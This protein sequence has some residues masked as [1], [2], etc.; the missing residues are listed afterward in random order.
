MVRFLG[1]RLLVAIPVLFGVV[2]LVFLVLRLIPGDPAQIV[3]MGTNASPERVEQVRHQMGLD[4]PWFT[5]FILY[6]GGLLQHARGFCAITNPL[7]N[8]YKRLVPGYEAPVY[9]A[10]SQ[11]NR[12]ALVRVPVYHPGKEQATRCEV[13]RA[14][15]GAEDHRCATAGTV[16]VRRG[17]WRRRLARRRGGGRLGE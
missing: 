13:C 15:E 16:P 10:W 1:R 11:R 6:I 2:V 3:L 14:D 4:Q 12:S 5:Q 7:V 8:S 17:A 9:C